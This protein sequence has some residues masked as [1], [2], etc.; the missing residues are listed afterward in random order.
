MS[1]V[2]IRWSNFDFVI[3]RSTGAKKS[4]IHLRFGFALGIENVHL[5][6]TLP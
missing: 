4:L 3:S 2:T 6:S 5:I 1:F